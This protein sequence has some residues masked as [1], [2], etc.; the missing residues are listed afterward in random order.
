M[1]K[2]PFIPSPISFIRGGNIR[3]EPGKPVRRADKPPWRSGKFS[4]YANQEMFSSLKPLPRA[5][6][7]RQ[8][9]WR[10]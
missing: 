6:C 4:Y 9:I 5:S 8:K 10:G 7:G 3:P 2:D 1:A